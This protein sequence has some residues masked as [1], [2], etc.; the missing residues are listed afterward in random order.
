[1]ADK[2]SEAVRGARSVVEEDQASFTDEGRRGKHFSGGRKVA[3]L[4]H[5]GANTPDTDASEPRR[6]AR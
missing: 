4:P 3:H 5:V 2:K 1:M 6:R